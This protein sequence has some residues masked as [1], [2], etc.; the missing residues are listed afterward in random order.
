M[1]IIWMVT[2][3]GLW[4]VVLLLAF[5]L[6]GALRSLALLRWRL[7][8]LETITP[9]HIGR[10]GHRPGKKAPDFK[11]PTISGGEVTLHDYANRKLLLVFIQPG[12]GPC[13]EITPELPSGSPAWNPRDESNRE[14]SKRQQTPARAG[15]CLGAL[16]DT[17]PC[18]TTAASEESISGCV[19]STRRRVSG[20]LG[21]NQLYSRRTRS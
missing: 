1:N 20:A 8:E 2:H 17:V 21:S 7:E 18:S 9:K 6:C 13:H 11:L 12:C 3:L 4:M 10:S 14:E 5:V 15:A 19:D 16:A